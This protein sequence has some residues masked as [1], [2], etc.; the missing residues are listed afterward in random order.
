MFADIDDDGKLDAVA[1]GPAY[2]DGD[3][4]PLQGVCLCI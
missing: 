3:E 1:A 4:T 2:D